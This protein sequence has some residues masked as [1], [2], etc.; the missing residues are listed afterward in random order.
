MRSWKNADLP[1]TH[2]RP[3]AKEGRSMHRKRGCNE[4]GLRVGDNVNMTRWGTI[5]TQLHASVSVP[6]ALPRLNTE[7][8]SGPDWQS[9]YLSILA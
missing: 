7:P 2:P 4:D 9:K 5:D 3:T 8:P 6:R 1:P